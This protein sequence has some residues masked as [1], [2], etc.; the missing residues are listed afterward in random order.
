MV[1]PMPASSQ[2]RLVLSNT[3]L[4]SHFRLRLRPRLQAAISSTVDSPQRSN[5]TLKVVSLFLP[6]PGKRIG[7]LSFN[8]GDENPTILRSSSAIFLAPLSLLQT[9]ALRGPPSGCKLLRCLYSPHR[10]R[11][12]LNVCCSV[13]FCGPLCNS[14]LP[15]EP[16]CNRAVYI[17]I[18]LLV[19]NFF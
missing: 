1:V 13:S 19:V 12:T 18:Y 2:T 8:S 3:L 9:D 15:Q 5:R 6:S 17:L 10:R 16:S 14:S 7:G 4:S 11:R